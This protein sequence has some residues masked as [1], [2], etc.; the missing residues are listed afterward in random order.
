MLP[1][2][3]VGVAILCLVPHAQAAWPTDPA[4]NLLISGSRHRQI[5]ARMAP[6]MSG[7]ALIM[8]QDYRIDTGGD[9]YAARALAD[10]T[11]PWTTFGKAITTGPA[12]VYEI[13]VASDGAGGAL[14]GWKNPGST[15]HVQRFDAQ[16]AA[17]WGANGVLLGSGVS[18]INGDYV[19][20]VD[21][22]LQGA[23]VVWRSVNDI[24]AQ[25]V[26]AAG[27]LMWGPSPLPICTAPGIQYSPTIAADGQGGAFLA[28][29]DYRGGI[30]SEG[31]AQH[32]DAAGTVSWA[33]DG[34]LIFTGPSP[35]DHTAEILVDG[36]GGAFFAT[37][38][39]KRIDANG[40]VMWGPVAIRTSGTGRQRLAPDGAGGVFI[41]I[42]DYEVDNDV[43]AQRFDAAG[44]RPWGPNGV[45]VCTAVGVQ[46]LS[47]LVSDGSGG[48][49]MVWEDA[50][51]GFGNKDVFGQRLDAAGNRLWATNG[52]PICTAIEDQIEP[53][54]VRSGA[55]GMIVAWTDERHIG[56]IAAEDIYAQHVDANGTLGYATN[57]ED[58]VLAGGLRLDVTSPAASDAHVGFGLARSL[59]VRLR[60]HDVSGRQRHEQ[61]LG[62]LGL[63]AHHLQLD[64]R[65]LASG[66]YIVSLQAGPS[67]AT[68]KLVVYR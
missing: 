10:G 22:G 3:L 68:R 46:L 45:P 67:T 32:V 51:L 15:A 33:V 50:R 27:N 39:L 23:I 4:T 37:G 25:R 35:Q 8:W 16:G 54:L 62:V 13:D 26:D 9:L 11:L 19:H 2:F 65:D 53:C 63:G 56:A 49:Y 48:M 59:P 61:D 14:V 28:W 58:P 55:G 64:V 6:D 38:E 36:A 24:V 21:D 57:V 42:D 20:V 34:I 30:V 40:Q 5:R 44:N 52:I 31:Y 1:R 12:W 17:L 60:V 66:C 41:S 47:Q 29:S 43:Y 18:S 7:G